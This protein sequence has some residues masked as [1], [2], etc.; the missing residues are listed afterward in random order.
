MRRTFFSKTSIVQSCADFRPEYHYYSTHPTEYSKTF[1]KTCTHIRCDD[2]HRR[3]RIMIHRSII[4]ITT[5]PYLPFILAFVDRKCGESKP[6]PAVLFM[7]LHSIFTACA[8]ALVVANRIIRQV[9]RAFRRS[10]HEQSVVA[11]IAKSV[12]LWIR[13]MLLLL[14]LSLHLYRVVPRE[15]SSYPPIPCSVVVSHLPLRY[16]KSPG[17]GY[18][19]P[20]TPPTGA[21]YLD[22]PPP[23]GIRRLL[24][25][26]RP[27]LSLPDHSSLPLLG[28]ELEFLSGLL[29]SARFCN[30][31]RGSGR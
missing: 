4:A 31:G 26:P 28:L 30:E 18:L 25:L 21:L 20:S 10:T 6:C 5:V 23:L 9:N 3:S 7:L 1:S 8:T 14:V 15:H 13:V 11:V 12:F 17:T 16:G 29:Y 27:P 19:L 22:D 2:L 24:L